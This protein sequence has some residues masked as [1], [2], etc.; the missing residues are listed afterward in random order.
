MLSRWRVVALLDRSIN[1]HQSTRREVD[2]PRQMFL[3]GYLIDRASGRLYSTQKQPDASAWRSPQDACI[4]RRDA[5]EHVPSTRICT[6]A[7]PNAYLLVSAILHDMEFVCS[8][9]TI[10]S[11]RSTVE[12]ASA[13]VRVPLTSRWARQ[14]QC[15]AW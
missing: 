8:E 2:A 1:Y 7:V 6:D 9:H 12:K 15:R 13:S 3:I 14:K 11:T 4:S 5:G 10:L